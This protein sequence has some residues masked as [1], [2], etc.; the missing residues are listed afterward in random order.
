MYRAGLVDD[1]RQN[2]RPADVDADDS[3]SAHDRWVT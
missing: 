2:L 3:V 1:A